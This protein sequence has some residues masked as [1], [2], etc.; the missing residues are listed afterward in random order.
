MYLLNVHFLGFHAASVGRRYRVFQQLRF[1]GRDLI[2]MNVKLFGQLCDR[3]FT[4]D[5]EQRYLRLNAGEWFR[6]ERLAKICSF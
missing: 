6:R 2:G 3:E 4:A 5:R 1:P